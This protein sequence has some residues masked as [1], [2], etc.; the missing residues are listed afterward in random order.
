MSPKEAIE[1]KQLFDILFETDNPD[2]LA[3]TVI[4]QIK[5]LLEPI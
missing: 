2:S 5:Q 1:K 4:A 3:Q